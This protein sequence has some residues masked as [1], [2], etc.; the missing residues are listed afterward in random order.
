MAR[1]QTSFGCSILVFPL[2]QYFAYAIYS[3]RNFSSLARTPCKI[4]KQRRK[5]FP[6]KRRYHFSIFMLASYRMVTGQ[7]HEQENFFQETTKGSGKELSSQKTKF[8][9]VCNL[10]IAIAVMRVVI[11]SL[12]RLEK[13][14]GLRKC[15]SWKEAGSRTNLMIQ[16]LSWNKQSKWM[17]KLGLPRAGIS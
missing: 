14:K 1:N 12:K 5:E 15:N 9:C 17:T 3:I 8:P 6:L 2:M 4:L 13:S 7:V 11:N 10:Q 16:L